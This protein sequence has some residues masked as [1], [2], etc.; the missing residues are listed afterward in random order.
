MQYENDKPIV[1][2]VDIVEALGGIVCVAG[3][4]IGIALINSGHLQGLMG[5]AMGLSMILPTLVG[6]LLLIAAGRI[7]RAVTANSNTQAELPQ[8]KN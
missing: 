1:A 4:F 3:V 8:E 6:G 7:L 2:S 5:F